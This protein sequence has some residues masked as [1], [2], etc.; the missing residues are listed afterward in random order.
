MIIFLIL[1]LIAFALS[2]ALSPAIRQVAFQVGAVDFPNERKIHTVPTPRVGG[3]IIVVSLSGAFLAAFG[4]AHLAPSSLAIDLTH[5]WPVLAGGVIVFLGGLFDGIRPLPVGGKFLIQTAGALI[6]M[7][8]GVR[9]DNVSLFGSDLM[10]LGL[11]ALP[12]TFLWIVAI[13]NAFNLVDGVDGLTVGLGSIAAGTCATLFFLQGD[14]QDA[15]VLIVVLGA[16]LGFLPHNFNPASIYLGDCGSL[17]IGYVLAV[18]AI[19]G[20]Q[21]TATALAIFVP[22]LV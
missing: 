22:L 17:L 7:G 2:W 3:V 14:V 11:F 12:L 8:L 4:L 5:W 16:L 15:L 18:T 1:F 6:A 19:I 9:I 13:T 21:K 10:N 20:T